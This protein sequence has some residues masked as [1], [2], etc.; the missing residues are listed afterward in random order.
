MKLVYQDYHDLT[1]QELPAKDKSVSA[2]QKNLPLLATEIFNSKTGVSPELMK[3][4]F[5]FVERRHD[6]TSDYTLERKRDH[7]IN[8]G[9]DRLSSLAP[10][11]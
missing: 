7:T 3:D 4:I 10:K 6:F 5:H 8:H 9:S 2:H 11:L 1:F